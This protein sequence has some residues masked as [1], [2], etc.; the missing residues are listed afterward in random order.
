MFSFTFQEEDNHKIRKLINFLFKQQHNDQILKLVGQ[1][2]SAIPKLSVVAWKMPQG[3]RW[4]QGKMYCHRHHANLRIFYFFIYYNASNH[5]QLKAVHIG[6]DK[7][8]ETH[9][10]LC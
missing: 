10:L 5:L 4:F 6:A 1:I 9:I 2:P 3:P 8:K 7:H